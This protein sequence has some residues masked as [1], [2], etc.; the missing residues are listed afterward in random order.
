MQGLL[1]TGSCGLNSAGFLRNKGGNDNAYNTHPERIGTDGRR[2]AGAKA[3]CCR[4]AVMSAGGVDQIPQRLDR[5]F[6]GDNGPPAALAA[7]PATAINLYERPRHRPPPES[8]AYVPELGARIE[9]DRNLTDGARRLARK[10][11]EVI[12]RQN[13]E[14]R[15]TGNHRHLPDEGAAP[16]APDRAALSAPPWN[17]RGYIRTEVVR[18][19][20]LAALHRPCGRP[21][22]AASCPPPR[23]AVAGASGGIQGRQKSH[24]I[25]GLR[26]SKGQGSA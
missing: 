26:D 22:P 21:M 7:K 1:A 16:F 12:Y 2:A 17:A 19:C 4:R 18:G 9:N 20:A 23:K 13:R 11:A 25:T 5:P 14:A 3:A 6:A 8:G 24:R 15:C 10:L